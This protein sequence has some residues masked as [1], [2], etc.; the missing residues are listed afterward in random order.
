LLHS[1]SARSFEAA[2]AKSSS[3]SFT[4]LCLSVLILQR[5]DRWTGEEE[6]SSPSST[7]MFSFDLSNSLKVSFDLLAVGL[8]RTNLGLCEGSSMFFMLFGKLLYSSPL[9]PASSSHSLVTFR[10]VELS[11]TSAIGSSSASKG[12]SLWTA[13]LLDG[14]KQSSSPCSSPP[15]LLASFS[16]NSSDAFAAS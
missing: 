14:C 8:L 12:T 11:C 6:L 3:H 13:Y 5:L 9:F 16:S 2:L 10:G 7:P 1:F 4:E 15:I